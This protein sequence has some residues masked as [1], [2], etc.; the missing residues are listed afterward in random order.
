[1]NTVGLVGG[2]GP[3]TT[4]DYYRRIIAAW[5]AVDP[6]SAPPLVIDSIDV[7]EVFRLVESDRSALADYLSASVDRLARAGADFGAITANMPHLVFDDVSARSAIPLISIIET[8]ADEARRRGLRRV[9]LLGTRF[10]MEA[11]MY[12]DGLRRRDIDVVVPDEAERIFIHDHYTNEM[13]KGVFRDDV[14]ERVISIVGR[15]RETED[16]DG[17]ILGGTELTLLLPFDTVAGV[18]ALNTT[19]IHVDAIVN[20]L[21]MVGNPSL[22]VVADDHVRGPVDAAVTILVY[23]DYECPHTRALELALARLRRLD[24]GPFRS[25][26]RHFPLRHVHP[27]AQRAAEAA[28]AV[29]TLAGADA[30]WVMHDGLFAHQDELDAAGLER[31]AAEAGVDPIA[32]RAVLETHRLADRVERDILSGRANGARGT[33]SVFINGVRYLGKRDVPSLRDAIGDVFRN[34]QAST[35]TPSA[36]E[37][38]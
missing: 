16:I 36:A 1:V 12:P 35:Y 2:L 21:R 8:C 18:P 6:A 14:R 22:Q 31:R 37:P 33:P 23:G 11:S 24:V 5:Q 20:R 13:I 34:S 4:I 29:Y 25:V 26:F 19:A 3:E 15:L 27:L 28:E 38:G 17:V 10:T 32:L 7:R 9:A 30:F